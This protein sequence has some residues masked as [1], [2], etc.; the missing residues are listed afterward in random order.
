MNTR[1]QSKLIYSWYG[2]PTSS[3]RKLRT[4]QYK[5]IIITSESSRTETCIQLGS[6]IL[7][8]G[9]NADQPYVAQLLDLYED[10]TQNKRAV[11]QWFCRID[12]IPPSKRKLLKREVFPQEVFFDQVFGYDTDI[13]AETIIKSTTV[14][15]L[16]PG[17]E[18]PIIFNKEQTFYV[19]QSWD[20]KCF[21]VLSPDTF[22]KLKEAKKKKGS[23]PDSLEPFIPLDI[24]TPVKKE[25]ECVVRSATKSKNVK[26]EIQSKH[27]LSKSSLAKDR[28]SQRVANDNKTP[29][30]RKKLDLS[31]PTRS[32][33]RLL[34]CE[35]LDL[36][37]DDCDATA[38]SKPSATKRKVKFTSDVLGSPPK[39][40]CSTDKSKSAA[41]AAEP[42]QRFSEI[43][44]SPYT[45]IK[46]FSDK[47][48]NLPVEDDTVS[49]VGHQKLGSQSPALTPRSRRTCAQ[50]ASALIAEHISMLTQEDDQSSSDSSYSSSSEEEEDDVPCTPEKKTKSS[51]IFST[52]KSS[53][54]SSVHTP[55][56]TPK[57]TVRFSFPLQP[58]PGT[59]KTPRN[60]TPEIP[61]RSQA[62][63]KPASVLEE[64]RLRLHVSAVP[65]SLPC[66]EEEFQDIYNFV[67]SKL[68]DG[69]GGCMYISGVPGTGKTATVHEVVR[70]LQQAAENDE[71]PS[72]QFVEINGMKLTDPHQAYVQILEL[73]TGQKVTAT[74]AAV[75]LAKLFS[76]PGP[77]RKSTVLI[78]DELDL[79][80]TQKQ[81]V[82]YNLFDWPTQKHSMLIILAIANTMDLPER[83]MMNRVASRLGLTR[84]SFQ[85]YTYKQ[86]QQIISSRLKGVKAFEEDAVQL[87][88][89]KVAALSGDARRCLDICRRATEICEFARQKG[90]PEIVRMAHV[91][92]AIDEMFSSPYINAIRN[93]SLHEQIFLKAIL[94]EFRRA[95]VEEATVQQVY[96]QHVALC[97]MEGMRSPSVSELMAICGR[98]G[99]CR[100]LL[101]EASAKYLHMRVRLNLSQDDVMY[102]LREE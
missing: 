46:D 62:A 93:A 69:T 96:Q 87:V 38:P 88:S 14:I 24:L 9:V 30:A 42:W 32:N 71:L 22:S 2:N 16:H 58:L 78:V 40:R 36:L 72:F 56:K 98:L 59:P 74:H 21:K 92:E 84:M 45:K 86:L 77:K 80:W 10:G 90:S 100:L 51:R 8:E 65:E 17:E 13:S 4:S 41:G 48:K 29:S 94:A 53:S 25:T 85:P 70:C 23:T 44:L 20:G 54:K 101:L 102:A 27:S 64:A 11:V 52:P 97:R 73:L 95:G 66:R 55:A 49:L 79:L 47:A 57:K 76:T 7:V 6:F 99:A 39:V 82:M 83:I 81:K 89:R 26:L 63:Q 34:G 60:A 28:Q 12:E 5:G 33:G 68:I 61:R 91:T 1:Q 19:K 3:D 50:R 43:Q 35:V 31:S 75:L 37:D 18:L 67:E 15:P